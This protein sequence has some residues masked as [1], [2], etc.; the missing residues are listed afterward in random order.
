MY[1]AYTVFVFSD[2]VYVWKRLV[3]VMNSCTVKKMYE[4][5]GMENLEFPCKRVLQ[6]FAMWG[7]IS[8]VV[9]L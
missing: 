5:K 7:K 3:I 9:F 6:C 1:Y 8:I 2:I 4:L